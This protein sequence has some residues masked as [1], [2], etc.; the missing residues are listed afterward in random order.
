M[1][2][3]HVASNVLYSVCTLESFR[4]FLCCDNPKLEKKLLRIKI[5]TFDIHVVL[6]KTEQ[7]MML[8]PCMITKDC[9]LLMTWWMKFPLARAADIRN[10]AQT[11]FASFPISDVTSHSITWPWISKK[12]FNVKSWWSRLETS[13]FSLLVCSEFIFFYSSLIFSFLWQFLSRDNITD[14][15]SLF[16]STV[17]LLLYQTLWHSKTWNLQW[18]FMC[19]TAFLPQINTHNYYHL[20]GLC[21]PL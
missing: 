13:L 4:F 3:G 20:Y 17:L 15:V 5:Y 9:F 6:N 18:T 1:W 8:T 16:H 2:P 14:V 10:T 19:L 12:N 11:F 7:W 21:H